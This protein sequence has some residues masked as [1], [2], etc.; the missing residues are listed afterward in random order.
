MDDELDAEELENHGLL[1][2]S[3]GEE[4]EDDDAFFDD[5][6]MAAYHQSSMVFNGTLPF[7]STLSLYDQFHPPA[8]NSPS[9]LPIQEDAQVSVLVHLSSASFVLDGRSP[10][11]LMPTLTYSSWTSKSSSQ[12]DRSVISCRALYRKSFPLIE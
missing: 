7:A 11:M 8:N 3:D 5:E 6:Q 12:W 1:P 10:L 4:E 9:M 2:V